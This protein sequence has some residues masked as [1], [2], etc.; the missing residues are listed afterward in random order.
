M[1]KIIIL[2]FLFILTLTSVASAYKP[3]RPTMRYKACLSNIRVIQG[4][5]EMYNMNSSTPINHLNDNSIDTLLKN[6]YLKIV[7]SKPES[8]CEYVSNGN[9]SEQGVVYCKYHGGV[10]ENKIKP[11]PEY[12]KVLEEY[13]AAQRQIKLIT[14]TFYSFIGLFI[15]Y[16]FYRFFI[17]LFPPK[18]KITD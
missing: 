16:C 2:C 9:L 11:S 5:V 15:L 13:L 14:Y 18:E 4:A 8:S 17:F 7:P 1:K 10:D 6:N 3:D 12:I